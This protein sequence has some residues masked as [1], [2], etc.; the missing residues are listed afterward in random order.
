MSI[1]L[2]A[3]A[4][5]ITIAIAS[6]FQP[7]LAQKITIKV[8]SKETEKPQAETTAPFSGIRPAVDVAI[9]L[10]TSNSM[11]GLINQAK[12]QLWTIIEEFQT[13]KKNGKTPNLRVSVFEYGNSGL[14]ASEGYIRQVV[15]LTDDLDMVSK[16][17]FALKTN[18]GDEYCGKVIEEAL[19]R[20]DWSDDSNSYKA[21]FIAGNEPFTQG[22]VDPSDACRKAIS[23]GI[24]VNTIH[25]GD[26]NAGVSGNWNLGEKVAEGSFLNINQD[27]AVVQIKCPQ[28]P[29]LIELNAKLNK[30]YLWF[31]D[32]ETRLNLSSNQHAQ[33]TNS[34]G[35]G[36]SSL[37]KRVSAKCS[38]VYSNRGR[39]LVDTCKSDVE[40]GADYFATMDKLKP[41]Q[42]PE[43]MQEMTPDERKAHVK[44]LAATRAEIQEKIAQL[45]EQRA[46]HE[47][48]ERAKLAEES[49][50]ETLGSAITQAVRSQLVTN[51]FKT[52]E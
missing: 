40:S 22:S 31:G 12:S 21:I 47:Q 7:T 29:I 20:L 23:Q 13:A 8:N 32:Q 42:L 38:D 24:V 11:D 2:K 37:S 28:D 52:G 35:L 39:D 25:C 51:G 36:W 5:V 16:A 33:D 41:E 26:Y 43:A 4:F 48:K 30:T 46:E 14:P 10:D 3:T 9:L 1:R 50:E 49:D 6:A 18:G 44:K 34:R 17:L 19:K 15:Q 45:S 27:R